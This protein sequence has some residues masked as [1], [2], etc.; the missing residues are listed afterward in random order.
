MDEWGQEEAFR[1]R[2]PVIPLLAMLAEDPRNE[3]EELAPGMYLGP[4][5]P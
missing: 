3:L 1:F 5:P 4:K 2:R